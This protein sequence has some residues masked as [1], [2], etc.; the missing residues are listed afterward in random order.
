MKSRSYVC[1]NRGKV[2]FEF[3]RLE[4]FRVKMTEEQA[5]SENSKNLVEKEAYDRIKS[6]FEILDI[7][8][9]PTENSIINVGLINGKIKM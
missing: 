4:I 8:F 9:H 1:I 6:K 2:N 7:L 5:E 3:L